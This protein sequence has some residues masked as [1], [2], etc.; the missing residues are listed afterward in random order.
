MKKEKKVRTKKPLDPVKQFRD[1]M[2]NTLRRAFFRYWERTK[3][4]QA[5]RVDR[6]LYRCAACLKVDK[7]KGH[8]IDHIDPVVDPKVGFIGWDEYIKR[9]FCSA[10]NLQL[11]CKACHDIKTDKERQ[12]RKLAKTGIYSI[13]R[14]EKISKAK[15]GVPNTKIQVPIIGAY[16]GIETIFNS[17]KE[18]AE[19]TK[20]PRKRITDILIGRRAQSKGWMF[21]RVVNKNPCKHE[22][23]W[24]DRTTSEEDQS[25]H[26]RCSDCGI[27]LK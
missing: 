27:I 25:M 10:S 9:L 18:A 22:N 8:H 13:D 12:E 7:I 20:I 21:K 19:V 23:T 6:G 24:F 16:F 5:A 17:T 11:L 3:A 4:L 14:P 1:W 26:T 2:K 15:L